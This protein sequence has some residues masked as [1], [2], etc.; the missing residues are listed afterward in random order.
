MAEV[1]TEPAGA[2]G[3]DFT[4]SLIAGLDFENHSLVLSNRREEAQVFLSKS[5]NRREDFLT[6]RAFMVFIVQEKENQEYDWA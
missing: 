4:A 5:N 2:V 3:T 6:H 1:Q